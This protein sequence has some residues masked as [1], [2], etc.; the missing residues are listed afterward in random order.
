MGWAGAGSRLSPAGLVDCRPSSEV[1]GVRHTVEPGRVQIHNLRGLG[2]SRRRK[3]FGVKC[4]SLATQ[5]PAQTRESEVP[6]G[7]VRV[8]QA[9]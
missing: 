7:R 8:S 5:G 1:Q 3:C 9:S 6:A 2:V 4:C